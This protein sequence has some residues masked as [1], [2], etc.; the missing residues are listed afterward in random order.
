MQAGERLCAVQEPTSELLFPTAGLVAL[1]ALAPDGRSVGA[2]LLGAEGAVGAAVALGLGQSPWDA[3]V[4][5]NGTYEAMPAATFRQL[6]AGEP[7]FHKAAAAYARTLFELSTE[8]LAC[9]RYHEIGSRVA[10]W[11]VLLDDRA[12]LDPVA[13]TVELLT[14]L[15]GV[16]AEVLPPV[17]ERVDGLAVLT[18]DEDTDDAEL[19]GPVLV[20]VRDR[21]ALE[22]RACACLVTARR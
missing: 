18:L 7:E 14:T 16:A 1:L 13:P 6:C 12:R 22:R 2:A 20:A 17:I 11:L 8:A 10:K 5:A 3:L 15:L 4:V 21:A 9:A 19:A